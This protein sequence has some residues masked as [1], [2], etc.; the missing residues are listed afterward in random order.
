MRY[1]VSYFIGM[2][3][4]NFGFGNCQVRTERK[5]ETADDLR[6]LTEQISRENCDGGKPVIVNFMP[7]PE[8]EM[9]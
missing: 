1:F 9:T 4:G 8:G 2:E 5:I 7:W 3:D 6:D